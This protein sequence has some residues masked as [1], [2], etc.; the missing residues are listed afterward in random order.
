MG[1]FGLFGKDKKKEK[2]QLEN[3]Q[4]VEAEETAETTEIPD[5]QTENVKQ[6]A[7]LDAKEQQ[8][9]E[10]KAAIPEEKNDST[11]S[12]DDPANSTTVN[13][14]LD[15]AED[16]VENEDE[17][18]EAAQ[19][20]L[21]ESEPVTAP[22]I[23]SFVNSQGEKVSNNYSFT[24]KLGQK[25]E[26]DEIPVVP[27]FKLEIPDDFNYVIGKTEQYVKIRC[28]PQ[29]VTCQIVPIDE[30]G[31]KLPHAKTEGPIKGTPGELIKDLPTIE[32][33]SIY[34][35]NKYYYPEQDGNIEVTYGANMQSIDIYYKTEDG[36][37]LKKEAIKG[38]TDSNYT[39]DLDKYNFP[40]YELS[41]SPANLQGTFSTKPKAINI[42]YKPV[43]TKLHIS[44]RDQTGNDIY[45]AKTLTGPY[46]QAFSITPPKIEG[47]ELDSDPSLLRGHYGKAD[48]YVDLRFRKATVSFK[49]H[50]W[51]NKAKTQSASQ[52]RIISGIVDDTYSVTIPQREGYRTSQSIVTG[53]FKANNNPD[54]DIFYTKIHCTATVYLVDLAGRQLPGIKPIV[55]S[56]D[57]GEQYLIN[58]PEVEG[59]ERPQKEI[60]D[61]FQ[62]PQHVKRIRYTPQKAVI[63]VHYVNKKEG[64]AELDQHPVKEITGWVGST[65]MVKPELFDGFTCVEKPKNRIGTFTVKPQDIVFKYVPNLSEIVIHSYDDSDKPLGL[66]ITKKGLFGQHYK[67]DTH[68]KGY[69]FLHASAKLEGTFPSTRQDIDVF[70]KAERAQ[71]VLIPINAKKKQ[72]DERYNIVVSGLINEDWSC[73]LPSVPGYAKPLNKINKEVEK[74]GGK[75]TPDLNDQQW[76]LQYRPKNEVVTVHFI[77]KGGTLDGTHPYQDYDIKGKMDE[78][79]HQEAYKIDGYTAEPKIIEGKFTAEPQDRTVYYSVN[80]EDYQIQFVGP[81]DKIVGQMPKG[82][83][84]YKQA[85]PITSVPTGYHLPNGVDPKVILSGKSKYQVKVEPEDVTVNIVTQTDDGI[86]LNQTAQITGKYHEPQVFK[87]PDI[88]GYLPTKGDTIKINFELDQDTYPIIYRPRECRLVIKYYNTSGDLIPN[89]DGQKQV[90]K[91]GK[92]LE[93]YKFSAPRIPGYFAVGMNNSVKEGYFDLNNDEIA[94]IYRAGSDQMSAAITPLKDLVSEAKPIAHNAIKKNNNQPKAQLEKKIENSSTTDSHSETDITEAKDNKPKAALVHRSPIVPTAMAQIPEEQSQKTQSTANSKS[95]PGSKFI[96]PV[97]RPATKKDSN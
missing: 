91:T 93:H 29:T 89:A 51:F 70:Y 75:I 22:I 64:N 85:I 31:N 71:F 77:Y 38:K 47:F 94:F 34:A 2:D 11:N 69:T 17:E 8:T 49:L 5:D 6:E 30:G 10:E 24:G 76:P 79:Y 84:Y 33:Y 19:E 86:S 4:Q 92:Y 80:Y 74:V 68:R 83:G 52:D 45:P 9:A 16:Q 59:F 39:I 66:P 36:D 40:G 63:R 87:V 7:T 48:K 25:L 37:V 18:N 46:K 3:Q 43:T 78:H 97:D 23:L 65:F 44:Y 60:K 1:L 28:V 82:H 26:K 15:Q 72:I 54:I 20:L 81:H 88:Y 50:Y 55:K 21:K 53:K 56:G 67:I 58:L 61:V 14:R 42:I 12:E 95:Q 27:G 73:H 13:K 35:A 96:R 57:W 90:V 41:K 32:G 62:E